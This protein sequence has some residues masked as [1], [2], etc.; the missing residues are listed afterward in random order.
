M[1]SQPFWVTVIVAVLALSTVGPRSPGAWAQQASCPPGWEWNQNSFGQ[2]PCTVASALATVCLDSNSFTIYPL[3][4]G[5]YYYPPEQSGTLDCE[6]NTVW[7]SLIE[8][9]AS[10]Q[11]GVV[12]SWI[13]W[14]DACVT[15]YVTQYPYDV[16][17]E[18][19]IPQW[20]FYNVTTL[21]SETYSDAVAMSVGSD[22]EDTPD[23]TTTPSVGNS[24]G[25]SRVK[26]KTGAIVGGVVGGVA[27]LIILAAAA[28]ALQWRKQSRFPSGIRKE[29]DH[30][31]RQTV[32][33]VLT[34]TSTTNFPYSTHHDT[35]GPQSQD[36]DHGMPEM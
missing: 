27:A 8:A 18:T 11:G 28:L 32:S 17:S 36:W 6:C 1:D 34:P 21:P 15:V 2:D 20:A 31:M 25:T 13:T 7:Y 3:A 4:Q 33:P 5:E 19:E 29:S 35:G 24:T 14:T 22:P 12:Q 23:P 26:S 9:C 10:C 16:P 30:D